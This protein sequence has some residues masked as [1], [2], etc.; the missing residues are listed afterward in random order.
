MRFANM[1]ELKEKTAFIFSMA[2]KGED[3]IVTYK[4][5]PRAVIHGL[6]E[7]DIEDYIIANSPRIRKILDEAEKDYKKGKFKTLDDYIEERKKEVGR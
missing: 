2:D 5:K 4:G 3:I 6:T 7:E 1:K